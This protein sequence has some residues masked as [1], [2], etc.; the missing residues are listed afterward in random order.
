MKSESWCPGLRYPVASNFSPPWKRY[1]PPWQLKWNP[2][3]ETVSAHNSKHIR[4]CAIIGMVCNSLGQSK[5]LIGTY[6]HSLL[7]KVKVIE[8]QDFRFVYGF[9]M[10]RY[11][12]AALQFRIRKIY[13]KP[14]DRGAYFF[15]KAI[16]L[17]DL[18]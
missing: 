7:L 10:L 9:C 12:Q 11:L 17:G 18:L 14:S 15:R 16:R 6:W 8:Y 1:S 2:Y 4:Y 5:C 3:H 13:G